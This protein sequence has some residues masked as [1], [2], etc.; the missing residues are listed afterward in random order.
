MVFPQDKC[1]SLPHISEPSNT[2][3]F[4][5]KQADYCSP[6][7]TPMQCDLATDVGKDICSTDLPSESRGEKTV[8]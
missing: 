3:S 5:D 6:L 8:F 4:M 7:G 2:L 1:G